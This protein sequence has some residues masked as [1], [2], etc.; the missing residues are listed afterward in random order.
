MTYTLNPTRAYYS[1]MFC[2]QVYTEIREEGHF[3]PHWN[4]IYHER[5]ENS[6]HNSTDGGYGYVS[7]AEIGEGTT[8]NARAIFHLPS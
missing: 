8:V 2:M 4:Y 3:P 6:G 7:N 1:Y 5:L